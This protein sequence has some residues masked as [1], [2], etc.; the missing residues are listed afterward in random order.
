MR[1]CIHSLLNLEDHEGGLRSISGDD[2]EMDEED[3]EALCNLFTTIGKTI[4]NP[5]AQPYMRIYFNKISVL[6]D[7]KKLSSRSRFM[8]KVRQIV[9]IF[10]HVSHTKLIISTL[11]TH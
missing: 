9:C 5:K 1:F 4:D 7:N 2:G 8:Y 3:H 10:Y 11:H 6:S